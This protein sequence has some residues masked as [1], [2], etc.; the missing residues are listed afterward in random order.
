MWRVR[1]AAV[2]IGRKVSLGMWMAGV[3]P[4][5]VGRSVRC[6][7]GHHLRHAPRRGHLLALRF[8]PRPRFSRRPAADRCAVLYQ[9]GVTEVR[10]EIGVRLWALG[11]SESAVGSCLSYSALLVTSVIPI[12]PQA[13]RRDAFFP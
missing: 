6:A 12:C 4:A 7:R 9:F 3:F 11:F 8:S 5:A 2:C 10:P 1:P 13:L